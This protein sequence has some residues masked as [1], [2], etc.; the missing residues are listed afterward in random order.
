LILT[1]QEVEEV[2]RDCVEELLGSEVYDESRV[3]GWIST[4]IERTM[5]RLYDKGKP[6]KFMSKNYLATCF[7]MQKTGVGLQTITSS[8]FEGGTDVSLQYIW[9]KEKSKDQ[10][11]RNMH[12]IVTVFAVAY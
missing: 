8:Y 9:P 2:I 5:K 6:Y 12:C 7:I 11:N 1:V 10:A 3:T 4:L